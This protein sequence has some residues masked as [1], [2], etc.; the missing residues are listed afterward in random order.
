V[1]K[2]HIENME[3]CTKCNTGEFYSFRGEKTT[4]RFACVISMV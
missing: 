4:G 3:I 1:K 2:E